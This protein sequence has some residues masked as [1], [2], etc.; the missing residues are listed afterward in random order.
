MSTATALNT[1]MPHAE[2][3]Q[4]PLSCDARVLTII[5]TTY[6][7]M[8]GARATKPEIIQAIDDAYPFAER[9]GYVFTVW[10]R[11]RKAFLIKHQLSDIPQA[12]L[13]N[14]KKGTPS[15]RT[16]LSLISK[17]GQSCKD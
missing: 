17:R 12:R 16:Q 9:T 8:V 14:R 4:K 6:L 2:G 11:T 15:Q 5:T 1:T 10:R 7:A 13:R 3:A